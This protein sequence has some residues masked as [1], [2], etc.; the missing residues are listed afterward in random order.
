MIRKDTNFCAQVLEA[1]AILD[2]NFHLS[3]FF[4]LILLF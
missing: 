1:L 3:F 2:K 4:I